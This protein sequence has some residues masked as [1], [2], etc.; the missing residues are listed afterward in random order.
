M[1]YG[2]DDLCCVL[3]FLCNRFTGTKNLH[4]IHMFIFDSSPRSAIMSCLGFFCSKP[5][6][7]SACG[8]KTYNLHSAWCFGCYVALA[9]EKCIDFNSTASFNR[10]IAFRWFRGD[11]K[12]LCACFDS[13]FQASLTFEVFFLFRFLIFISRTVS[14]Q[15]FFII[16]PFFLPSFVTIIQRGFEARVWNI[17]A[18]VSTTFLNSLHNV[19]DSRANDG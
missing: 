10:Q 17:T 1:R 5:L 13:A 2:S 6:W 11:D 7:F 15:F 19:S 12:R 8:L 14:R 4:R 9:F 18:L 16:S 3:F